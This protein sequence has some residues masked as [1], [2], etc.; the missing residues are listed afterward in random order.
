MSR[1]LHEL[2]DSIPQC[3]CAD[4]HRLSRRLADLRREK[5]PDDA[6]LTTLQT[7]VLASMQKVQQRQTARPTVSYPEELPVSG[8]RDE[9]KQAISDHQVV[10][11]C[12]ETGS[13]KTTQLPKICLELGRGTKGL[14]GHT[15]P[16]RLAA[17]SVAARIAEELQCE[18]G[19]HVGYKVRFKDRVSAQSYIKLMTDGI[20][21]AEIQQDR[22]LN[23]YD[24]LIIDEAH[25]R[26]L[27][28]DFLL[29]YLQRLLS[30]RPELKLIITSA[31]I[32]PERFAH[33]FNHAPIIN[34]SG[35]TY[36]VEVRYRPLLN[37]DEDSKD[38][39]MH[40]AILD[41]VDELERE[42]PGDILVFL[43]GEREIRNTAEAL[44]KH[45]PP[46]TEILPL[47]ARLSAAEQSRI[48]QPHQ[49]RRIILSTNVAETS[50]TVPGIRF[51]IDT[52]L[53]RM[54]R[55]SYRTKVQ[56]LPIEKVS[57]AGAN[58]RKGR[59][60]R[61]SAGICIRLYDEE[62]FNN[63]P[64]FTE[65]EILRTNLASVILQ[66]MSLQ[67]G[68]IEAFPFVD[69]PDPR[70]IKDG[71]RLLEEL[72][73][74]DQ[75]R[76]NQ[77]GRALAR[78]PVDP[79]LA[80]IILAAAQYG[81]LHEILIITAAL[82]IQDPRE[83]PM[84]KQ[85]QADEARDKF[86]DEQSDFLALL[87]VWNFYT[88]QRKHLSQNKLR[89]LCKQNFLSYVRME[90]WRDI[91]QQ[92]HSLCGEL[93]M[94]INSE[95]AGY[96][97]I[98]QSLLSGFLSH[99]GLKDEEQGYHGARNSKF[100]I[101][102]GSGLQ[103]KR[104]KWIMAASLMETTRLYGLTV[105]QIK[106]EWIEQQAQHLLNR[107]YSEAHWEKR[108][109]QVAAF[110]KTSLYGLII[111]PKR[112]VNYGPINPVEA[113][114]IFIREAL[115]YRQY[116]T[117]AAFYL[118]NSTLI[119][120]VEELEHKSR[121]QDILIDA[122][123]L[124]RFYEER[125]PTG[126]YSGKHF[127][128]WRKEAE[129]DNPQLL[130]VDKDYLMQ[131]AA[132]HVTDQQF[133]KTL[134]INGVQLAL[135][136]HFEPGHPADGVTLNVPL[137]LLN[138]LHSEQFD[139]L[140][141]GLLKEKITLL[142]KSLPK[143]LR[144]NFVP[145]PDFAAACIQAMQPDG[146]AL[147]PV[148]SQT[149]HRITGIEVPLASWQPD[150]LPAHLLMNYRILDARGKQLDLGRDLAAL[151]QEYRS[152]VSE[153][154]STAMQWE[155]EQDGLIEW[156][157]PDLPEH[158]E[159]KQQGME[160]RGFP[161][162]VDEKESVAIRVFDN[163]QLAKSKHR[164]GLKRLFMLQLQQPIKYLQKNLPG[165]QQLCLHYAPVGKCDDLKQDIIEA[166]IERLFLPEGSNIR[167]QQ[168]FE[169]QLEQGKPQLITTAT[170]ICQIIADVLP[171]FHAI[172]KQIGGRL[173]PAMLDAVQDIKSQLQHLITPGFVRN[174]P[175]PWLSQL[176]RYLKAIETRLHK[177]TQDPNR[178]RKQT[179]TINK[180]Q[181]L[182]LDHLDTYQDKESFVEYRWM[183]EELRVSL[184][185][186]ELKTFK[187]VSPERVEKLWQA[188][189]K[190]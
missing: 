49:G 22:F 162:L 132:E 125:I 48:F 95:P 31:T 69:A 71:Y 168:A 146:R 121:R 130:F 50:L 114:D 160:I 167:S 76:I 9:I 75:Q 180:Y 11:I 147:L 93:K 52:G 165:I 143:Q 153:Q 44:R 138:Q 117:S 99:I 149:L 8:S 68:D 65:P 126:I 74:I 109:A 103:K 66:M 25:E 64:L 97:N 136:Y 92:L 13:G 182:Y 100:M 94:A 3:L 128:K 173:S 101:F 27:N 86:Q 45:H 33:H 137:P 120:E 83:R 190:Q 20:L 111:N 57:Q 58:Q 4:Q 51:V 78:F 108:P 82:S 18:L 39:D 67:L 73:A 116:N 189:T 185:A 10:I 91:H 106:P 161:A 172:R 148:L 55:Y 107:S 87:N 134:S 36:P 155:I 72:Q 61:V 59:C 144:R 47:F 70:Y 40:T 177:L 140:V 188:V 77:T 15:Q 7:D 2:A 152:Q 29:G 141:P 98:H 79:R 23:Q 6:R 42:G 16:R 102:P 113:R 35:R 151:Q 32:D 81:A 159:L 166:A 127:E 62:D 123:T 105:A 169:E 88:E 19:T 157:C 170:A 104:P 124:Y 110:E 156:S 154:F 175:E 174:T 14:I 17:R 38:R 46:Q 133:P 163:P 122:E 89:K 150:S 43:S 30:K 80:R 26:S 142:I 96:D 21:L 118:H 129:R 84:D 28:I 135:D 139:W 176:P 56:R 171:R 145:A 131:H 12:G 164:K 90:E 179:A 183:L 85:Q 1:L 178:D 119:D 34:V 54:S 53:V 187:P 41:A 63:R 186:Q 158:L 60:G 5:K 115:A 37:D 24:T 181:R 112:L 184:F